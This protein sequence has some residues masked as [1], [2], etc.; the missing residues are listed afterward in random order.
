MTSI[1]ILTW[2]PRDAV[3][4]GAPDAVPGAIIPL[5]VGLIVSA[6]YVSFYFKL[7]SF[8]AFDHKG[9]VWT[10]RYTSRCDMTLLQNWQFT[11]IFSCCLRMK[12]PGNYY[13]RI[14][15]WILIEGSQVSEPE[16][17]FFQIQFISSMEIHGVYALPLSGCY[18]RAHDQ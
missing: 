17:D 4:G 14:P 5:L 2:P 6:N 13:N 10:S 18:P 7:R 8:L 16:F 3:P 9:E 12:I 15:D 11:S 1:H